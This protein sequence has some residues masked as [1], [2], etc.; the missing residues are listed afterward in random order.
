ME[1]KRRES[2]EKLKVSNYILTAIL[3]IATVSQ[4]FWFM[5]PQF[6]L[7]GVRNFNAL[8]LILTI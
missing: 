1:E 5:G 4:V 6:Q 2:N 7:S 8:I 3:V